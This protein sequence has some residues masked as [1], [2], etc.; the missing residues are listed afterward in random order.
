MKIACSTDY[1]RRLIV[2]DLPPTIDGLRN[3]LESLEITIQYTDPNPC[4]N[5]AKAIVLDNVIIPAIVKAL[6]SKP[7][8]KTRSS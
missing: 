2:S 4:G 3:D 8:V 1:N 7:R 6:N 5:G